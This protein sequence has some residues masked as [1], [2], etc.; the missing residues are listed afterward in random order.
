MINAFP[1]VRLAKA[2]QLP[3]LVGLAQADRHAVYAP[4]HII[5]KDDQM[6]G[7]FSVGARPLVLAWLSTQKLQ[8]RDSFSLINLVE[9]QLSL[10]GVRGAVFPVQKESPFYPLMNNLGFVNAGNYDLFCKD[11]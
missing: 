2:D 3:A 4:T 5:W 11:F 8:S 6:V 10:G 7:Y 9:N 1:Q